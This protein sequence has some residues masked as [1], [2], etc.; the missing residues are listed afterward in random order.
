MLLGRNFS[1]AFYI[2][3]VVLIKVLVGRDEAQGLWKSLPIDFN[4]LLLAN[5]L[6]PILGQQAQE[7]EKPTTSY[8][9]G[10]IDF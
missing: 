3:T 2:M 4:P 10:R 8:S 5:S 6:F 1:A 7:N 9:A